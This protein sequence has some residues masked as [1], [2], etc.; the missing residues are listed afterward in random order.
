MSKPEPELLIRVCQAG[1]RLH[2]AADTYEQERASVGLYERI[3][4]HVDAIHALLAP[5]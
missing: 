5:R 4:S 2:F 1:V 3:R